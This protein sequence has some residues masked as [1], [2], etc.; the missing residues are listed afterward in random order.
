MTKK[1]SATVAII[2]LIVAGFFAYLYRDSFRK[3]VIQIF[4]TIRPASAAIRRRTPNA[5]EGPVK[6]LTFGMGTEYK[7]TSIKVIPLNELATNKYAHPS[8]ELKSES[9]SVPLR[10]FSYGSPIRGMHP[11][12][13]NAAPD[14]LLPNVPYRLL[15]EA[16]SLRGQ[17]DFTITDDNQL[18]P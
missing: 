13:K 1:E 3:P 9:N 7:L 5:A 14:P 18:T 10:A 4:H 2:V 6:A 17:H 11:A 12:V 8:W 16:G 15:I